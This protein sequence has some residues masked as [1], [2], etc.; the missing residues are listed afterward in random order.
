MDSERTN[1]RRY[2]RYGARGL[3]CI[4]E[5]AAGRNAR[6]QSVGIAAS[7]AQFPIA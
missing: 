7:A 2:V 6:K 5:P 3:T 1:V 4:I